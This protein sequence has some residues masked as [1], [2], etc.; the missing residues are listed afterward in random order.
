[1]GD[2]LGGAVDLSGAWLQFTVLPFHRTN[3][4]GS[5]YI[6]VHAGQHVSFV[7]VVY[8]EVGLCDFVDQ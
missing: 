4:D 5:T 7:W 2:G 6:S 8:G 1:M 3:G